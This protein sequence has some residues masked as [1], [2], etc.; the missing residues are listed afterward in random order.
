MSPGTGDLR[1]PLLPVTADDHGPWVI[2]V[3]TILLI[4]SIMATV[5]TLISRI[6]VTR[7]ISWGDFVL[8]L[9]C[10]RCFQELSMVRS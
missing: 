5:V 3:S 10:V 1:P 6:R 9:G 2:V 7:E 4:L 8:A